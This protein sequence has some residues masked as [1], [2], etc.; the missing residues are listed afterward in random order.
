MRRAHEAALRRDVE[1]ALA[2]LARLRAVEK[3]ARVVVDKRPWQTVDPDAYMCIPRVQF[4]ALRAA[5]AA[6]EGI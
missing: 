1:T 4:D 3:A 6:R 2:E 5:L